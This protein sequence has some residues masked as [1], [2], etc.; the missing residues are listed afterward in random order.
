M[1][2]V[3]IFE[4]GNPFIHING[5]SP[6]KEVTYKLNK[7]KLLWRVKGRGEVKKQKLNLRFQLK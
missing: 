1:V 3:L 4:L 7:V 5:F 6:V 2:F